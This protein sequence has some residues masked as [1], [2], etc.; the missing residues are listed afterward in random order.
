MSDLFWT[1]FDS[2]S[3]YNT[4]FK[5]AYIASSAYIVYLMVNDYKPTH[6]PNIDTFKV[7]YLLAASAALALLL[8]N[9]FLYTP[10]EVT[11]IHSSTR[12]IFTEFMSDALDVLNLARSCRY[13]ASAVH[14]AADGRGRNYHDALSVRARNLSRILHSQLDMA[15]LHRRDWAPSGARRHNRRH[16][17]DSI[18]LRLLLHLLHKVRQSRILHELRATARY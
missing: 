9:R 11:P 7:Q 13:T 6:D 8:P 18:I 5:V 2:S 3:L 1:A 4:L 10:T 16:S 12:T 14:A 17:P 15:I